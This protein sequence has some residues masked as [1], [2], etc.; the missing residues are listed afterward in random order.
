[1]ITAND[2]PDSN[3]LNY[4]VPDYVTTII[5]T[6]PILCTTKANYLGAPVA[7]V[8]AETVEQ[9]EAARDAVEVEYEVLPN[10][11]TP[12]DSLS[13]GAVP[14]RPEYEVNNTF[15]SFLKKNGD[16][17]SAERAMS[18]SDAVVSARFITSRQP[19]LIIEPDNAMA[20]T[21]GDRLTVMSTNRCHTSA[22][23]AA[24]RCDRH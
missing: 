17:D 1:M 14:I 10:Y 13:K 19:H 21:D 12:E 16:R 6:E 11:M 23:Q 22:P 18:D 24:Q 4:Y 9:A 15:T 7:I 20:F 5:P 8:V 2:V 3:T